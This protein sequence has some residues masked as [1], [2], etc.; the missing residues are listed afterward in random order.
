M[1]FVWYWR[2]VSILV[3]TFMLLSGVM[4]VTGGSLYA[5][6]PA[7]N[8]LPAAGLP[9]TMFSFYAT[10]FDGEEPVVYWFNSPDGSVYGDPARYVTYS[11]QGRADWT[12]RAPDNATPGTWVAV[13]QSTRD[14]PRQNFQQ[15]I[16]FEILPVEQP[17]AESTAEQPFPEPSASYPGAAVEPAEGPPSTRFSFYATDF[18]DNEK[19]AYWFNAPDGQVYGDAYDYVV[20]AY[21]GRADWRWTAPGDAQPGLWNVVATGMESGV[22]RII[23]FRI[24]DFSTGYIPTNSPGVAVEPAW[25]V[26]GDRFAFSADGF[27]P[28]ELVYFWV[29]DPT[30]EQYRKHKYKVQP[31]EQGVAYWNWK[32]PEDA[33]NG[34]WSM[35]V[36]GQESQE[37]KV[38]YFEVR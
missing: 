26:P 31:N 38:I 9:G 23:E 22:R 15:T 4:L 30:G 8:V 34:I 5:Q 1:G 3:V 20:H 33:V 18:E 10:G 24:V 16:Q 12:W 6:Q 19:V 11:Y 29:T 14:A 27:L 17:P 35:N 7:T 32:T 13:V 28:R 25:G 2:K 37:Q 36:M 21:D